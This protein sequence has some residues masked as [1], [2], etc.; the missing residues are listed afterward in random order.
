MSY[1]QHSLI[2]VWTSEHEIWWADESIF[3]IVLFLCTSCLG[4]T[5]LVCDIICLL[6]VEIENVPCFKSCL[7]TCK[8][9]QNFQLRIKAFVSTNVTSLVWL[10]KLTILEHVLLFSQQ[11]RDFKKVQVVKWSTCSFCKRTWKNYMCFFWKD[12]RSCWTMI[13]K[14]T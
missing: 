3:V 14:P 4:C 2:E 13:R 7:K 11:K 10:Y 5:A 12:T 1:A 9:K 6:S 8:T